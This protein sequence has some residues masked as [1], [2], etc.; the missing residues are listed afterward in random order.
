MFL[1]ESRSNS[2]QWCRRSAISRMLVKAYL[3]SKENLEAAKS[4][5]TALSEKLPEYKVF[6]SKW[7][8]CAIALF[9][10]LSLMAMAEIKV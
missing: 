8:G 5:A 2:Y 10:T 1:E 3:K 7:C 9:A 6:L 4:L